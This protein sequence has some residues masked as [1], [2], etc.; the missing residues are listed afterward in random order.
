[1]IWNAWATFSV[2]QMYVGLFVIAIIGFLLTAILNVIE[3]FVIPW[4]AQ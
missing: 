2:E 4:R 3:R 1:M